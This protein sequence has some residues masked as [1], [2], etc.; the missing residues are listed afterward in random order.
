MYKTLIRPD[1][2]LPVLFLRS[3]PLTHLIEFLTHARTSWK[4]TLAGV[5]AAVL[6][7]GPQIK[8]YL[9]WM[10]NALQ[11]P[12]FDWNKAGLGLVIAFMG[13]V[14]RDGDKRSEDHAL[15]EDPSNWF[16]DVPK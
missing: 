6:L 15:I 8:H 2:T 16:K 3:H 4:T 10:L 7:N 5:V 14:A 11:Q 9:E 12:D 13:A 1:I